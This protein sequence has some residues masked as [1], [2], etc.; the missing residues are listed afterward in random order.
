MSKNSHLELH[1]GDKVKWQYYFFYLKKLKRYLIAQPRRKK[2]KER[3]KQIYKQLKIEIEFQVNIRLTL[4]VINILGSIQKAI[5]SK[6]MAKKNHQ[7]E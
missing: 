5:F 7:L 6:K 4:P 2:E 1:H 3:K